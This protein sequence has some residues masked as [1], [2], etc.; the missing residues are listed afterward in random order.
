MKR[1]IVFWTLG[2]LGLSAMAGEDGWKCEWFGMGCPEGEQ[3]AVLLDLGR[4]NTNTGFLFF[5]GDTAVIRKTL[6]LTFSDRAISKGDKLILQVEAAAL[7]S[8]VSVSVD[9]QNCLAPAQVE[10]RARQSSQ[11][12]T[13]QWVVPPTGEDVDLTGALNVTPVGF[14]R[15]GSMPLAGKKGVSLEMLRLQGEVD[16]D[17]HWAKRLTFWFWLITLTIVSLIKFFIAPVFRHPRMKVNRVHV[18]VFPEEGPFI[19]G[20]GMPIETVK[21]RGARQVWLLGSSRKKRTKKSFWRDFL[22]GR[23]VI[24]V[25][26]YIGE[27][28]L[29]IR[30]AN[31]RGRGIRLEVLCWQDNQKRP[32][33]VTSN[34]EPEENQVR[35]VGEGQSRVLQ[36]EI[37]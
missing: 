4:Q 5:D 21:W 14:D 17:W 27:A 29:H 36:F 3:N 24:E 31:N 1:W 28:E 7:P 19:Q 8:G 22:F 15:A 18:Q 11:R 23:T 9:G 6:E 20:L 12:V 34:A 37:E 26:D 25:R 35:F 33:I 16:D 32:S 10:I 13:L 30:K 2:L